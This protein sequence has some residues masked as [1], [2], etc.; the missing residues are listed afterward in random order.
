MPIPLSTMAP[1]YP[2]KI[3][4]LL[5]ICFSLNFFNNPDHRRILHCFVFFKDSHLGF[6]LS[7]PTPHPQVDRSFL[8]YDALSRFLLLSMSSL[9]PS[10]PASAYEMSQVPIMLSNAIRS[11]FT[12][13]SNPNLLTISSSS[14]FPRP[15]LLLARNKNGKSTYSVTTI[16]SQDLLKCGSWYKR[17][18]C[19]GLE[20]QIK[21][22]SDERE[23]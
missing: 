14:M 5:S 10:V 6:Q 13:F 12:N 17:K 2:L 4:G 19:L 7:L 20:A 15:A 3:A 1:N 9:I 18:A 16:Q 21:S 8:P 22:G 11:T 23:P